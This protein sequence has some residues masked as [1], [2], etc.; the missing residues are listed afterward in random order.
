MQSMDSCL[1]ALYEQ[2][3]I[4]YDTALTYCTDPKLFAQR[5]QAQ[6]DTEGRMSSAV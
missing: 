1:M 4:T 5:H 2:G 3:E 6:N